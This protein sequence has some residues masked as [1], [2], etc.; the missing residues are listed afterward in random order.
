MVRGEVGGQTGGEVGGQTGG[1]DVVERRERVWVRV[2]YP[3][4]VVVLFEAWALVC[5]CAGG[6]GYI[7]NV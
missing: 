4:W 6:G 2:S 7:I 1:E 3:G 5:V